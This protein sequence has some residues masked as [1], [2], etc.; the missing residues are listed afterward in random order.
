MYYITQLFSD[1]PMENEILNTFNF[2]F[3]TD[4]WQG[5]LTDQEV[6]DPLLPSHLYSDK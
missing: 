5:Q 6:T 2:W 4:H 3:T 1:C